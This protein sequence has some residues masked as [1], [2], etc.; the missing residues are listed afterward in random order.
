MRRTVAALV[1]SLAGCVEAEADAVLHDRK[2]HLVQRARLGEPL[3]AVDALEPLDDRFFDDLLAVADGE[4]RGIET[5]PLDRKGGVFRK[6]ALPGEGLRTLEQLVEAFRL[7]AAELE[8]HALADAQI[9]VRARKLARAA[10]KADAPVFRRD[11]F[12][13]QSAQLVCDRPFQT[14]QAGHAQLPFHI[15]SRSSFVFVLFDKHDTTIF[16]R[17]KSRKKELFRRIENKNAR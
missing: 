16:L 9:D 6:D 14:E 17:C 4:E 11:V 8:E 10:V 12:H 15:P 1:Q 7:K 2:L 3:D 5:V 13:I